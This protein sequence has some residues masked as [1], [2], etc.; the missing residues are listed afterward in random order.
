MNC[1]KCNAELKP[2]ARFCH[3]CGADSAAGQT[4]PPADQN[5]PNYNQGQ[6]PQGGQG[7]DFAKI[8]AKNKTFA[9]V[10][11]VG[12]ISTFL[13]LISIPYYGSYSVMRETEGVL[14]LILYIAFIAFNLFGATIQM[15]AKTKGNMPKYLSYGVAACAGILL[16]RLLPDGG[17][18]YVAFGFWV[19][20]AAAIATVL[21]THDVIKMNK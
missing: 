9:I 10:G 8:P 13:P 3:V 21:F 5:Q 19:F 15:D 1:P 14:S 18:G 2:G 16:I 7:F 20:L 6:Q 4:T 12:A 17:L 11:L